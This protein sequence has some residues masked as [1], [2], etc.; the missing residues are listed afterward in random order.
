MKQTKLNN[1]KPMFFLFISI[2]CLPITIIAIIMVLSIDIDYGKL[3]YLVL[4][5]LLLV[6]LVILIFLYSFNNF[7]INIMEYNGYYILH[8]MLYSLKTK[9]IHKNDIEKIYFVKMFF[10]A[11]VNNDDPYSDEYYYVIFKMN[12]NKFLKIPY[13][14]KKNLSFFNSINHQELTLDKMNKLMKK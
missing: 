4:P 14:L 6:I 8:Y 3:R 11:T 7:S 5:L 2:I 9:R 12:N 10:K 1:K 13:I